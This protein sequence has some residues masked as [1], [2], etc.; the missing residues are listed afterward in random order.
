MYAPLVNVTLAEVT[1][2]NWRAVAEVEPRHDQRR[3][4]AP[5][6]RY[7][8]LGLYD[9][10]W[11]SLAVEHDGDVVGHVMWAFDPEEGAHWI[12]GVVI[13]AGRQGEG[14][15]RQTMNALMRHL[16]VTEDATAFALSYQPQNLPAR[17]LYA[18]LGFEETGEV[19]DDEVVARFR[20][21]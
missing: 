15:G 12:G 20:A 8:C 6:T 1:R 21:G 14:L 9:G 5:V 13:D 10:V 2:H 17:S 18:S 4:V 7:L 11:H 19:V 3:F 16:E